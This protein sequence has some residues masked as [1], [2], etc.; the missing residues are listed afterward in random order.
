[1]Y[2]RKIPRPPLHLHAISLAYSLILALTSDTEP[3]LR[4][5]SSRF[6]VLPH[7]CPS[8]Q[9]PPCPLLHRLPPGLLPS[10]RRPLTIAAIRVGS[11]HHPTLPRPARKPRNCLPVPHHPHKL[12][13]E[14]IELLLI[15]IPGQSPQER[16][17]LLRRPFLPRQ[18]QIGKAR[19]CVERERV[20][21]EIR[22]NGGRSEDR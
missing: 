12:R 20:N 14:L 18:E 21:R 11:H 8:G 5:F 19:G 9:S 4:L 6:I 2:R 13:N 16:S 22:D 10:A 15:S 3:T 1:M 17:H 7:V